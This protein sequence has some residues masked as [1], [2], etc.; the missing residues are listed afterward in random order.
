MAVS[1][2]EGTAPN[3]C[4]TS[5]LALL[6]PS[7]SSSLSLQLACLLLGKGLAQH[8]QY[9]ARQQSS[10]GFS[11]HVQLF[12]LLL[13]PGSPDTWVL[14]PALGRAVWPGEEGVALLGGPW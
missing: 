3:G 2:H 1:N 5:F 4:K 7:Q 8:V 11:L 9:L 13:P 14:S 6:P 10:L 12:Q